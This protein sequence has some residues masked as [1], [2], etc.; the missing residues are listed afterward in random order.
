MAL[1][2]CICLALLLCISL[3][4]PANMQDRQNTFV[5]APEPFTL[6]EGSSF[7]ASNASDTPRKSVIRKETIQSDVEE[8]LEIIGK[9]YPAAVNKEA[10]TDSAIT[11]MLKAL[12]PHSN[13]YNPSEFEDLISEQES[14]YSGTGSSIAGFERNG[15][16]ETFV[17]STF[18]D[19]PAARAGLRFADRIIAVNGK[20]VTSESP[21]AI[22]DLIRGKRG[23]TARVTVERAKSGLF[24]MV[25]MKRERVHEPAVPKGFILKDKIGYIEISNGFSNATFNELEIALADLHRQGM[26]S[27]VLDIRGNGG[28]I[29]EQAIRVAE[30]FLPAGSTIVSQRGRYS[31]DSRI[32]KAGKARYESL[33]MVLLVD[34]NTASASEVL[35]GALQDNDRAL[36]VGEKT[37]G[38]GLVQSVLN[39]PDGAGL[40][41]TAARYYT[42]TGR[43]IQ[44]N[45]A[46]TGL[47][48]YFHHRQIAE[49]GTSVYAAKTLTN[50]IVYGGNGITPDDMSTK[51]LL[52]D[53]KMPLLD[54]IFFFA[55]EILNEDGMGISSIRQKIIFGEQVV[56]PNLKKRFSQFAAGKAD[57]S[58]M[59]PSLS[60]DDE[61][62]RSMLTYYLQMGTFG[63]ESANRA[64]IESDP[65]VAQAVRIL[66]RSA[67]LAAEADKTRS[68]P[69][70]EKSSLSLVLNE[71]R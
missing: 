12:D 24:E 66:P 71:Q 45:Y 20:N 5:P 54:P 31:N 51:P 4:R 2:K 29:L 39:L 17:I 63:L 64:K 59:L 22:R 35:A 8:A 7:S 18:P 46:D 37:F 42:P 44:R 65:Q 40:T 32:W 27:L 28:G 13:Y 67:L 47:Y 53:D 10:L 50:R 3:V 14:E 33:P 57:W 30:K 55:R 60:Q 43:S 15:R 9:N 52:S 58:K 19:S 56:D 36:I 61:F 69:R 6:T 25:E 49:V 41:L 70:K 26:T 23:T 48:D 34:E 21:D 1:R 16:I 11:S 68:T 38:K 62:V